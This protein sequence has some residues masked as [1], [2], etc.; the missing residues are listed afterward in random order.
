MKKIQNKLRLVFQLP[1]RS[2]LDASHVEK[3]SIL[4]T[5]KMSVFQFETCETCRN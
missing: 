2:C 3:Y 1:L 5:P 4:P